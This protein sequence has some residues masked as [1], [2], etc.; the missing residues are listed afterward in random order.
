MAEKTQRTRFGLLRHAE[1]VWNREKKIQG[2]GDSPLTREGS[3][4]AETYRANRGIRLTI[5]VIGRTATEK[6]RFE[7]R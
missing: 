7:F 5:P 3:R 1:T 4:Q 2:V 6:L